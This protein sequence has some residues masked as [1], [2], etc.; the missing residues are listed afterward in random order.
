M[1]LGMNHSDELHC[2]PVI[3]CSGCIYVTATPSANRCHNHRSGI[4]IER[5]TQIKQ[6]RED[7]ER[8]EAPDLNLPLQ[9]EGVSTSRQA[10]EDSGGVLGGQVWS[11]MEWWGQW[12][13]RESGREKTQRRANDSWL[14]ALQTVP[15]PGC[16]LASAEKVCVCVCSVNV[17]RREQTKA[18]ML[19]LAG[20]FCCTRRRLTAP[21]QKSLWDFWS[22]HE[23]SLGVEEVFTGIQYVVDQNKLLGNFDSMRNSMSVSFSWVFAA[24]NN[25]DKN[26]HTAPS[27]TWELIFKHFL[28]IC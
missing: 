1:M 22:F 7:T 21:L 5:E 8:R 16:A 4:T 3:S 17:R 10:M 2:R 14:S 19:T 20:S 15:P 11:P 23:Q 13:A 12:R 24:L 6:R 26:K 28:A 25:N 27:G 9:M 18:L